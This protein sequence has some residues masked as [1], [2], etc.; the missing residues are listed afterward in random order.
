MLVPS[1]VV[2]WIHIFSAER[3]LDSTRG[4]S[5]V[6]FVITKLLSKENSFAFWTI[7]VLRH[8]H[9]FFKEMLFDLF[10]FDYLLAFPA[11]CKHRAFFPIVDV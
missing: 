4:I 5:P 9:A 7:F 8:I 1:G 6:A 10:D 11:A 2:I 3:T